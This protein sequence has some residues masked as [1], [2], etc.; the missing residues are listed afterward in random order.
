MNTWKSTKLLLSWLAIV[1]VI[2]LT[3]N[4]S[5]VSL[6]PNFGQQGKL[7][8][9]LSTE[10]SPKT[11]FVFREITELDDGAFLLGFE[12]ERPQSFY[13]GIVERNFSSVKLIKIR[14]NG[15]IEPQYGD[16]GI[17]SIPLEYS[18]RILALNKL[19]NGKIMLVVEGGTNRC[20]VVLSVFRLTVDGILDDTFGDEGKVSKHFGS[21]DKYVCDGYDYDNFYVRSD[22]AFTQNDDVLAVISGPGLYNSSFFGDIPVSINQQGEIRVKAQ[23]GCTSMTEVSGSHNMFCADDDIQSTNTR[24]FYKR[25][26][27]SDQDS[28]ELSNTIDFAQ[29]LDVPYDDE[30]LSF[31]NYDMEGTNEG[32]IYSLMNVSQTAYQNSEWQE[33]YNQNILFKLNSESEIAIESFNDG[34]LTEETLPLLQHARR[35]SVQS[36][37]R[38]FLLADN[39]ISKIND[40]GQLDSSYGDDGTFTF[41]SDN[42]THL[43][44]MVSQDTNDIYIVQSNDDVLQVTRLNSEGFVDTDFSSNGVLTYHLS[45]LNDNRTSTFVESKA[46]AA[47]LM[48]E[49]SLRI[50]LQSRGTTLSTKV[51][52]SGM[53]DDLFGFDGIAEKDVTEEGE[54]L[55]IR[56]FNDGSWL[57]LTSEGLYKY[58]VLGELDTTFASGGVYLTEANY[59]DVLILDEEDIFLLGDRGSLS[60]YI[61]KLSANGELDTEFG[62]QGIRE[63]KLGS[64]GLGIF[65][66]D[67]TQVTVDSRTALK[68]EIRSP[69]HLYATLAENSTIDLH[70][71][72]N[73]LQKDPDFDFIHNWPCF[74]KLRLDS[75][76]DV[77]SSFADDGVYRMCSD[78]PVDYEEALVP[79]AQ[80]TYQDN[81]IQLVSEE[82]LNVDIDERMSS[83]L[84]M[85]VLDQNGLEISRSRHRYAELSKNHF[86]RLYA[87][88]ILGAAMQPDNKVLVATQHGDGPYEL[89]VFRLNQDGS[90]DEKFANE[91]VFL[92]LDK[93]AYVDFKDFT[94]TN[95]GQMFLSGQGHGNAVVFNL[96]E[97]NVAPVIL[98]GEVSEITTSEDTNADEIILLARDENGDSLNWEITQNAKLGSIDV[99][100]EG[101]QIRFTYVPEQDKN[102]SDSFMVKVS[103]WR[104]GEQSKI[105]NVEITPVNDQPTLTISDVQSSVVSGTQVSIV[106]D[107][108][109]V[110]GDVL[111]LSWDQIS[112]PNLSIDDHS[113]STLTFEVPQVSDNTQL[114]IEV[115]VSDGTVEISETIS[116]TVLPLTEPTNENSSSGGPFAPVFIVLLLLARYFRRN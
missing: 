4:A 114:A 16:E 89:L 91:G 85:L 35:L 42:F 101:D 83:G 95:D 37:S 60:L 67:A 49:E 54:R 86:S 10:D 70:F 43:E 19:T 102:G 62:A 116:F 103:D 30:G 104:G 79:F 96:Q 97:L 63:I 33:V 112:G 74:Y 64:D 20:S 44:W 31:L 36:G 100:V 58:N 94:M 22:I 53:V 84:T 113:D 2:P 48:N 73:E 45:N 14:Q 1:F 5:D 110:D 17:Y 26:D 38:F 107:I 109:D 57:V 9:D 15:E 55:Q 7:S 8:I 88:D 108:E 18:D 13:N 71:R 61:L 77:I 12:E 72:V 78:S 69:I 59:N 52:F 46:I 23:T 80:F 92:P 82:W 90:L 105:F 99:N 11:N 25:F 81:L 51:N 3:S 39:S 93:R 27:F 87:S 111:T 40:E 24:Y 115:T 41:S 106:A 29:L 28:I 66:E 21:G 34:I 56:N 6:N 32:E 76:G 65:A 68:R 98:G 47:S 75:H 50:D